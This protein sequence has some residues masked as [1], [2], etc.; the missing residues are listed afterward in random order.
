ME[1]ATRL[2]VIGADALDKDLVLRWADEGVL[3][4]FRR[5]LETSAWGVTEA[6]PGL[7]VGAVWPSFWTATSPARH[8]RYCFEQLKPGTY[9]RVRI[10][11]TDTQAPAFWRALSSAGKRVA[12]LDVPKTYV[13]SGLNGLQVVD[14]G[15]HDPDFE[16]PLTWPE[17]FANEV[18]SRYGRDEVGN[19]NAHGR[20]GEYGKLRDQLVARTRARG[21]MISDVID[22]SDWDAV[23]AVFS[24]SHCVGHQC[25]HL[26][27]VSHPRHDA[28][29]AREVGSPMRDVY[30]AIDAEIGRILDS[31][32]PSTDVIVFGSHGMRSHFDATFLLD[33]MLR[34]IERPRVAPSGPRKR[35]PLA[36]R[37]WGRIPAPVR[38]V[39]APLKEPAKARLGIEGPAARRC[40]A[41]P[42]N[43]AYGA[44]RVN[45]VG[46]EPAGRVRAEDLDAFCRDLERD[47]KSFVNLDTG[48]PLVRGVMR[49][50]DFYRGPNME[51]LP[52]LIIEWNRDTPVSRVHSEKTGEIVGTYTKCRTGDHSPFGVFFARGARVKPGPVRRS[53]SVMDY[54]PTIAD[55]LGVPLADVDGHSFAGLFDGSAVEPPASG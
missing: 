30:R 49:A 12:I 13:E 9:E 27:D 36:K 35:R 6:P 23:V 19:C 53:F 10:H 17:P 3:P 21:R 34:R 54:G 7:F 1:M 37:I 29:V 51:H 18:L 31:V 32:G 55:R 42:N 5:L 43:D 45:L 25:W 40:F 8:A 46:R 11:P 41:V 22:K 38:R 52:D 16:G 47:L 48:E 26:H 24:E 20:A 28:A 2:L 39:L 14:W 4:G 44:V 15:T 50:A 33:E